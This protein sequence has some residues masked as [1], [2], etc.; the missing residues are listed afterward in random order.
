MRSTSEYVS[1]GHP[2][3]VADLIVSHLLDR[4][5]ER[6]PKTR[7]ALE[8]QVKDNFVTLG[9][10]VTSRA[11]L[12]NAE[13]DGFVREAVRDI[14]Y[15]REYAADWGADNAL[16]A[17][18][19]RVTAHIGSQSPDIAQGVDADGWGDQGIFWGMATGGRDTDMMPRD[20]FLAR[21]I[22]M[23]LYDLALRGD[24]PIGLDIKTQVAVD[25]GDVAQIVVAAP[26]REASLAGE[27]RDVAL[28]VARRHAARVDAGCVIVNG[29][30][31][32]VRHASQGDCGTTGRKLAVDFY[33]GN[34]R[35]GGGSPWGKDAT[36]ADVTL[37]V[38]AR[39]LAVDAAWRMGLETVY[40]AISCC[41]GRRDID[42][43]FL[44][45]RHNEMERRVEGRPAREVIASLGLDRPVFAWK[46]R[47]GLFDAP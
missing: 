39:A 23:E 33:G 24:L 18:N 12:T 6:D 17:E 31:A 21:Q 44:D 19:L 16:D 28:R 37:N 36:K 2:D 29:T 42:I 32:Y 27:V 4:H 5:L 11:G 13:I 47:N 7:F 22:G 25:G 26:M 35:V 46:K 20:H 41:I 45:G 43:T 8:C 30:G 1:P 38:Y 10:E 3:S 40:C 34:C 14:G 15:T 9:G